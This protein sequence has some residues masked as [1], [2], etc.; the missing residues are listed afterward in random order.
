MAITVVL[1][2][3]SSIIDENSVVLSITIKQNPQE[4]LLWVCRVLLR[5]LDYYLLNSIDVE[6]TCEEE[7]TSA[8]ASNNNFLLVSSFMV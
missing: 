6:I 1:I 5:C 3:L 4:V 7:G 8:D 2:V